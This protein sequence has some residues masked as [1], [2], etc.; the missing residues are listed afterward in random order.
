M[1]YELCHKNKVV[2]SVHYEPETNM[3]S[4]IVEIYDEE[5]I[6]VGL[7]CIEN[8]NLSTALQFWWESRIIP[9]NRSKYKN[10]LLEV[11]T[12]LS[13]SCGFN[14]SDQYWIRPKNNDI[15]W[16]NNNFYTNNFNEDI[17]KY[18]TGIKSGPFSAMNSNTPDL[19][20]NGEQD[21]RWVIAGNVR[22]LIKYGKAPYYEQPFNEM[23][24]TEICRRLNFPHAQYS[25]IIKG[26]DN[27]VIYS[28]CPDFIDENTEFVPAGFIQYE[29]KKE[30]NDS[31]F[32]HLIKCCKQLGMKDMNIIEAGLSQMV[33]LDYI[34]ANEDRHYGNFGFIRNADTLEWIGLAPN[35]DTGNAMFY[36][37]PT[38][39]LRK[40]SSIMENVK[41]KTFATDQKKQLILFSDRIARLNIDFTKLKNID[42]YYENILSRNPKVDNERISLLSKMLL[43]RIENA[44]AII[45]SRNNITKSFLEDISSATQ[46]DYFLRIKETM[47]KYQ[48]KGGLEKAVVNNYIRRL[49]AKNPE[50][51]AYL[52]KEDIKR[53]IR[54]KTKSSDS[55]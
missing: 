43:Q 36:E 34:T 52:I 24:A 8:F 12:M 1:I 11:N 21:K 13:N 41:C 27:P 51:L 54:K 17:G 5:H 35:F 37:Y 3:F 39:D 10:Y 47:N 48:N 23:L 32:I 30:K 42:K 28:S 50:N 14:L 38:S 53:V 31:S 18:L 15:Q 45:Y 9:K 33:L 55:E 49:N 26:K 29:K 19:F 46:N 25:V 7:K 20:S 40:S 16:E 22:K 2:L 44:Q 6:P 4:D